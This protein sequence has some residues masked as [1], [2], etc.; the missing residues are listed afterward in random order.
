VSVHPIEFRY[1]SEEMRRLF[2]EEARLQYWLDVEAALARA[3]AALG[4]IPAAAAAEITEKASTRLVTVERVKAIEAEIQHDLMAM[5]KAFTEV[6]GPE[7]GRYIHF[8][9]T[10]YDIEDTALA[11]QLGAALEVLERDLLAVREAL[12]RRAAETK[13]L[14]C[15]GRT[16]GQQ[17]VPTTYGLKFAIYACEF[18]RHL[19]RLR[20]VRSRIRVGKMTGAVGTQ[21]S[22]GPDAPE[23]QRRVMADLGLEPAPVSNQVIQRDRHAEVVFL[24]ALIAA[25]AEKIAAELRNLQRTEIGEVY[26]SFSAKQVGSST[27]PHK[28][29]PHKSERICSLARILRGLVAPALENVPLEHER[30]L[31][32]SAAERVIFPES[33][34]LGDYLLRQLADVLGRL[35]FR[36]DNIRRNLDFTGGLV[37][38][39]NLMIGL[40][41][42]GL[43]RQ[44]AHELLRVAAQESFASRVPIK[45]VLLREARV[46]ERMS[47]ADLD[48]YLDPAAYIGTAVEQVER[49]LALIS[50]S[51]A[52]A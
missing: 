12:A 28:R 1:Y 31:T 13:R 39:E 19:E 16:H 24:V 47:E 32:N 8:G 11:L 4:H 20:Q 43:G 27:M 17:A 26:E 23:L 44:D 22:F 29:N 3:H 41:E 46:R 30:D 25:S 42:R 37:M 49:A 52:G 7:A 33:F 51:R 45:T 50:E 35:T 21:A 34:I 10:S 5:V 48:R 6:C 15:I 36:E 14:V 18:H 2:T 9:A 40:V 38:C